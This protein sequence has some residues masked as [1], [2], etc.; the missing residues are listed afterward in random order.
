MG[1]PIRIRFA[2]YS[3]PDTTHSRAIARFREALT[4]RLGGGVRVDLFWNVF[5]F[6]YKG[7]DLTNMVESGTL[8][9]CYSSTSYG[10]SNLIPELQIIDLPF[11]FRSLEHAHRALDG[12]LGAYFT[13][14]IEAKK[15][16]RVM[17]FWDNGFRHISNRL[18]P[19][20]TPVDCEGLRIRL[21]PNEVHEKTFALLGAD[22]RCSNLQVGL[23]NMA[24]GDLDAQENPLA[25]TMD[26]GIHRFHPHITTTGHFYAT[27][28]IYAHRE[29]FDAW[30]A[31]VQ[32]AVR[33]SVREAIQFQ[34]EAAQ[35]EERIKREQL[36]REGVAIVDLT[37]EERAR[38]EEAVSPILEEARRQMPDELFRLI[39]AS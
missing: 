17:G 11:V 36:E 18:R 37:E 35:E 29:S 5:D 32:S 23:E 2:G 21:M 3:P 1:D 26:Y 13:E 25:N 30:P 19:I 15:N 12:P 7:M 38:F 39:E 34:R 20:H 22:P 31:E 10:L 9:M 16:F 14:K 8:T 4:D 28:G 24:S 33:E 27:R 6:G